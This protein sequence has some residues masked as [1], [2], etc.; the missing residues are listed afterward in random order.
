MSRHRMARVPI[1]VSASAPGAVESA[2]G[3][4]TCR[5]RC[6][7][8]AD[9]QSAGEGRP[10]RSG[11]P[12]TV[13]V[14]PEASRRGQVAGAPALV[15]LEQL[16]GHGRAVLGALD[17]PEHA[18]GG[19]LVGPPGQA[20]QLEGEPGLVARSSWTRRASSPTSATSTTRRRPSG[21][22]TTPCCCSAPKRMGS[23][24]TSGMRLS[25]R[26]S[27]AGDLL[28]GAVVEDVAV[29]VDLDEGGARCGRGPGGTSPACACGPCRGCGPRRWP[30]RRGPG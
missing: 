26:A 20:G 21:S 4:R 24:C 15:G 23:P 13:Q 17:G 10:G 27:L 29:L 19:G 18:D 8:R 5:C 16:P 3:P 12:S 2:R 7:R 14:P 25:A 22:M 11:Q 9:R 1:G 28:E 30:R 6:R